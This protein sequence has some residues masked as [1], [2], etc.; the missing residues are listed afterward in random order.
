MRASFTYETII[1]DFLDSCQHRRNM[2]SNPLQEQITE[3]STGSSK[4][5]LVDISE[6]WD[7][8]IVQTGALEEYSSVQYPLYGTA[9]E[10]ISMSTFTSGLRLHFTLVGRACH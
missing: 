5:G 1:R 4:G 2:S 3:S 7:R 9:T 6:Y 8:H 10:A